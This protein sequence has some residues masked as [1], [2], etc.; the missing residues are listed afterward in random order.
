MGSIPNPFSD[1]VVFVPTKL[2]QYPPL[3]RMALQA[4]GQLRGRKRI[5]T[6]LPKTCH[7]AI[8]KELRKAEAEWWDPDGIWKEWHGCIKGV[9]PSAV[10]E[11]GKLLDPAAAYLSAVNCP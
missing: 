3:H 2:A 1:L 4:L 6:S 10:D 7:S 9:L 8:D 5:L 11:S